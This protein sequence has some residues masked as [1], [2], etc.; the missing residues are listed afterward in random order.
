MFISLVGLC[1]FNSFNFSLALC[2]ACDYELVEHGVAW[3]LFF[4]HYAWSFTAVIAL[5]HDGACC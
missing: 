3:I 2:L 4:L 5:E 1:G